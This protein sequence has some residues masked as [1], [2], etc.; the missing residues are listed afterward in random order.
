MRLLLKQHKLSFVGATRAESVSY[1][2]Y[3][4]F[5]TFLL[6]LN[7]VLSL[8]SDTTAFEYLRPFPI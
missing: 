6:P 3:L 5:H 4:S 2:L 7:D 1:C 8:S